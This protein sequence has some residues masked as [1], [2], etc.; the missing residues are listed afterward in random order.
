[1]TTIRFAAPVYPAGRHC[2]LCGTVTMGAVFPPHDAKDKWRW[3]L[4]PLGAIPSHTGTAKD[5]AKAKDAL[6]DVLANRLAEA[7]LRPIETMEV[8]P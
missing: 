3:S 5:E 7:G 4:F 1:M 2:L 6:L 8:H